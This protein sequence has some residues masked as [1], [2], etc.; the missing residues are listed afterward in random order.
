[1]L[2]ATLDTSCAVFLRRLNDH[3]L[4]REIGMLGLI[5]SIIIG[6]IVGVLARFFYPGAIHMGFIMTVLLGVGG[7]IVGGFIGTLINKP[8]PGAAFHPAGFL[9]S[10]VGSVILLFCARMFGLM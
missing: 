8:A 1:M 4:S 3:L 10:I 7:S 5:W 6:F 9:M 2:F